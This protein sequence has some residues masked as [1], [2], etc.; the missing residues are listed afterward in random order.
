MGRRVMRVEAHGDG[1][2][3]DDDDGFDGVVLATSSV[4]RP[5]SR[6]RRALAGPGR[7]GPCATSRS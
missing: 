1:W 7:R 2:R 4:E 6:S 3:V 5:S